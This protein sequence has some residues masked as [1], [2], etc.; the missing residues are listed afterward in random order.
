MKLG[1]STKHKHKKKK[2]LVSAGCGCVWFDSTGLDFMNIFGLT[3]CNTVFK[4]DFTEKY[5]ISK[6]T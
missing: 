1:T 3:A 4:I 5:S 6:D 2:N